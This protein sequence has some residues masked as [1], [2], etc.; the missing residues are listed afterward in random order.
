MTTKP[1]RKLV[2]GLVLLG[3][4]RI[5]APA[6]GSELDDLK[7][8]IQSMQKSMEQMQQRIAELEQ[9]NHKQK[10]QASSSRAAPPPAPVVQQETVST[11]SAPAASGDQVVTIA[12]TAVTIEGRASEIKDRPAMDDQQE[13][14]PRPNDLTLDPKYRGFVPIPNT[15][16]LIKFNAKPRV[17]FTDDPQN[18]GNPDRFVTAQ[19]P[20]DG[21]FF[22]GG[23][24]QFNVN[25]KGSQLSIDV[26]AP[27][28]PGSPRFYY[29]ND[30][31]GSGGGELP[32]RVRQLY[33]QIYNVVLGQ[34]FSVF[35]DPDAWPDTV[36]YEGPN[37]AIFARRPLV[38]YMLPLNKKW[39]LNLGL[40][41]PGSE[42]DTSIDP[43]AQQ[44]NHAPDGGMN[45]RWED[46]KYGHVQLGAILR[47]IGVKGPIVGNQSTFGWG[48]N[49]SSSL[50]VFDRDSLQTQLTYG[51][52]LFRYFNDD[53]F[54]NDAA[55]DSSGD[56]KAIPAFGAMIGYTHKWNDYLRSTASYGYVH[57]DNQFSQE[58]SAYHI[59]HYGSLNLVWQA[60][61]RLTLG[62]EGLYGFKEEKSGA[63]GDAF[64]IQL[65]A[66]Y[67]IFD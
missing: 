26:R 29:Q 7:A 45:V 9:E 57:L 66:V 4:L 25:A 15:P 34:T 60:R 18:T 14:A 16:I 55:F 43:G 47:D 61:K 64:R 20:V 32:F 1:S 23:G 27:E 54:N 11:T 33:G 17:D 5:T 39:Q 8:T 46:S 49:L 38:R 24:N 6:R 35:E 59:T 21:D 44:V 58:P 63:D 31:F 28:L 53:F 41:K 40:E 2:V 3:S 42:V 48:V 65:G 67:S 12:P 62:L 13:A 51:E 50:N 37:S 10:Q 56:L 36:D 30:F 52:G 19:I 22:Q